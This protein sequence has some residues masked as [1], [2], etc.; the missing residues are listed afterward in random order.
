MSQKFTAQQVIDR[1]TE[2][3]ID[4]WVEGESL[5]IAAP[6]RV[7]TPKILHVLN[8]YKPEII[9][10]LIVKAANEALELMDKLPETCVVCKRNINGWKADG[11]SDE[12]KAQLLAERWEYGEDATILY[13]Q[14]HNP[15]QAAIEAMKCEVGPER[16]AV[17]L[18]AGFGAG[19]IH[20]DPPGY[21]IDDRIQELLATETKSAP[22]VRT[23]SSTSAY[24]YTVQPDWSNHGFKRD[25]N[26]QWHSTQKEREASNPRTV[27]AFVPDA[28]HKSYTRSDL[29][30]MGIDLPDLMHQLDNENVARRV[31]NDM[32]FITDLVEG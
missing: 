19:Q 28:G 24:D 29:D 2:L 23:S 32:S 3:G 15:Q 27:A 30:A 5:K 6:S 20:I 11:L 17:I 8:E 13:C 7:I 25:E 14:A 18:H 9:P 1:A 4:L 12:V 31:I 22:V 16:L 26:G 10:L 21:T